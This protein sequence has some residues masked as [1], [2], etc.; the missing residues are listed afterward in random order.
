M[1]QRS[2]VSR[3]AGMS[4]VSY[5]VVKPR[6]DVWV[7]GDSH[8]EL[9]WL[10]GW[11]VS[12]VLMGGQAAVAADWPSFLGEGEGVERGEGV[13]LVEDLDDATVLWELQ[14]HM[15][16]GK[17]LY[18]D[19]MKYARG[20]GVEPFYGG[21]SS[22]IVAEGRVFVSYYKPN[23][24]VGAARQTWRTMTDPDVLAVLPEWFWSVTADDVLVAVD[25][26]TGE[27]AWEAVEANKGL[28]RLGHK[29]GHWT[30]SP[31]YA[32]VDGEGGEGG[33]GRVFSL[34]SAGLLYA[35][36]ARTGKRRWEVVARPELQQ[37]LREATQAGRLVWDGREQ[38]SLVVADGVV[39]VPHRGLSGFDAATGER[40]WRIDERVLSAFATPSIWRP[41]GRAYLLVHDG[42]AT[43]RL[44]DPRD[45]EILWTL[46]GLGQQ[47][48]TVEVAGDVAILNTGSASAE[49]E[50]SNGLFGAYRLSP[51]GAVRVW[52]LPD[53]P[54]YRHSWTLDRGAAVRAAVRGGISGGRV[55]LMVGIKPMNQL[56]TVAMDTG[57]VLSEQ[58]TRGVA[59]YVM[60]ERLLLYVDRAHTDRVTASW[61]SLEDPDRPRLLTHTTAFGFRTITGYEVPMQWPQVEGILYARTFAGM[62]AVDLRQPEATPRNQTLRMTIPGELLGKPEDVHATLTQRVGR[63]THGGFRESDRLHAIDAADAKWDGR[64]LTGTLRIDPRGIR[65]FGEYEVDAAADEGGDLSG[66]I[67]SRLPAF[68]QPIALEGTVFVMRRQPEWMPP[69]TR[70]LRLEDAA[71][72]R[73][74]RRG[75]LLLFLTI[76]DGKLD[77][78]AGF[79]DQT[80]KTPPVIDAAN[81]ELRG[82]RLTGT[83]RARFR[84]DEWTAP[85]TASADTA[86]TAAAEYQLDVDLTEADDGEMLGT[87]TG[88]YG[89]AWSQSMK[90]K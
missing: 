58:P 80:T 67:T 81:L 69:A 20:Q 15:G 23:G 19:S 45:G 60:G 70:V 76:R 77:S 46:D 71:I 73:G 55:Y 41:D 10:V 12:V 52:S 85:L 53:E 32:K 79:A 56:V 35:Y 5:K 9:A 29:R 36:D 88:T 49:D 51:E 75:R 13:E 74:G 82:N 22:P 31:V 3:W 6:A 24:K 18:P 17:G 68:D 87:Y 66:T 63:V 65:A 25:A 16:V 2:R 72:Q 26:K 90:L 64:R 44:I 11:F 43:A 4:Q 86:D 89:A 50:K 78:V 59:P 14:R 57:R 34:G 21:A 47:I 48:G 8:V 28:N 40:R 61:W 37:Q 62:T 84:P 42:D 1:H 54:R 33:E 83:V 7:G 38:S 27:V 39:V 30:V